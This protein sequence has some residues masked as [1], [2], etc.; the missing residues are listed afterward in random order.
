MNKIV[1]NGKEYAIK[2]INFMTFRKLEKLG[3]GVRALENFEENAFNVY[4]G[5]VAFNC[6]T[7]IDGADNII[8]EHI[9]NGGSLEDLLPLVEAFVESD[10]I[11]RLSAKK[12]K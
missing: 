8:N 4:S 2:E 9:L 12:K 10:F 5:L 11:Q 7:D 6:D 1:L 3:I